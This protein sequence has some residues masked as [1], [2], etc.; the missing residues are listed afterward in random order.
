[1]RDHVEDRRARIEKRYNQR[2]R[3]KR[4]RPVGDYI[5]NI[6]LEELRG[7]QAEFIDAGA[8]A[9]QRSQLRNLRTFAIKQMEEIKAEWREKREVIVDGVAKK[10]RF[11][12]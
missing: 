5:H 11:K 4:A 3:G 12:Q 2:K 1:V 6:S 10:I 9:D 8:K 7:Q